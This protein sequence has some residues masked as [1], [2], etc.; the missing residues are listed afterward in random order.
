[1]YYEFSIGTNFFVYSLLY[2]KKNLHTNKKKNGTRDGIE[3]AI[4]AKIMSFVCF[5]LK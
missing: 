1:M 3:T 4:S 5:T 2:T